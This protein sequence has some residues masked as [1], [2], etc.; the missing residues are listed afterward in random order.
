L[1]RWIAKGLVLSSVFFSP[2]VNSTAEVLEDRNITR[3]SR[4]QRIKAFFSRHKCPVEQYAEEFVMAADNNKLDW[5]LLP[6]IALVESS[7]GKVYRNNNI[8]GWSSCRRRFPTV[9]AGI[10]AVAERLA[11]APQYRG[12]D[13]DQILK[14]YNPRPIY[15]KTVK[16]VMIQL[17][18]E[19]I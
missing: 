3:D 6:S 17:S 13:L 18:A 7:G 12:K 10:H 2:A 4:F 1:K 8:F 16:R 15:G 19:P 5:R 14:T 9:K 11:N